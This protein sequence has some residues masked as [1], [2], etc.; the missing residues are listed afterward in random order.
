MQGPKPQISWVLWIRRKVGVLWEPPRLALGVALVSIVL[1]FA[2]VLPLFFGTDPFVQN[3]PA[4]LT[5]PVW[6]PKG[7]IEHPLGTDQLGRDILS[8]LMMGTRISLQIGLGAVAVS[9]IFGTAMGMISGY[10]GGWVDAVIQR[11][12]ELQMAFPFIAIALILMAFIRG[13]PLTIV[14]VF[15]FTGWPIYGRMIRGVTLAVRQR[16]FVEVA[17]SIG[18]LDAHIV[19]HHILPNIINTA[20]VLATLELSVLI[21]AEA[22]LSF[23]GIGI[24]PPTPSLGVMLGEGRVYL[25][26]AWWLATLPGLVLMFLTLGVNFLGDGLREALDPTLTESPIN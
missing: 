26:N 2:Y 13:T 22:A 3:L 19:Y 25:S 6:L 20:I 21:F 9:A 24:Q 12:A 16:E 18:G 17:E 11:W 10:S 4:R 8:R 5:P 7:V 14:L 15:S 1:I 23:L